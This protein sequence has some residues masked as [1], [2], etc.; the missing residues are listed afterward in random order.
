MTGKATDQ[1]EEDW[2]LKFSRLHRLGKIIMTPSN[3][4]YNILQHFTI[5]IKKK[6]NKDE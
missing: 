4:F 6:K 2:L 1:L 3:N 5:T